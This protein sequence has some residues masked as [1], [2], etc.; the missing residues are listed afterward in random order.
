MQSNFNAGFAAGPDGGVLV[1]V[2]EGMLAA[3]R[4]DEKK[5]QLSGDAWTIAADPG[6][7]AQFNFADF[8]VSSGG[9]LARRTGGLQTAELAWFDRSGRKLGRVE[10]PRAYL[11]VRLS[12]SGGQILTSQADPAAGISDL[13]LHEVDRQTSTRITFDSGRDDAPVW[14]PDGEQI[15][16][17]STRSG[18]SNLWVKA[19][20]GTGASRRLTESVH[21]QRPVDWSRDGRYLLYEESTDGR[22]TDLWLLPVDGPGKA[23][24]L[25]GSGANESQGRFSPDGKW[26][27]YVSDQS[28]R[29]EVYVRGFPPSQ[30]QWQVSESGGSQPVW[31]SDGR[32]LYFLAQD[33]SLYAAPVSSAGV[34]FDA[35][36]PVR[37]FPAETAAWGWD[38][39]R[40]DVSRD[41]QR[42]L[43]LTRPD[44]AAEPAIAVALNLFARPAP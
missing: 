13:W 35:R 19:A 37:L 41:G 21:H 15:A 11:S 12:G 36:D 34:R 26:I 20:S 44:G 16:F 17:A 25:A 42:F 40:Y 22:R 29:N 27:A 33:Q 1:F 5:L 3:Q 39:H 23:V 7:L 2:R 4:F 43:V 31:R 24:A 30:A 8:S 10:S 9:T 28:G 14:S 38:L 6:L 18:V 32:E